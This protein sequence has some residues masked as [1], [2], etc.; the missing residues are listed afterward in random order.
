MTTSPRALEIG[1]NV[2]KFVRETIIP[3]ESDIRRDHHG[4]PTDALM[5][6][7]REKGRAS[8]VQ[9]FDIAGAPRPLRN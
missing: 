7:M 2:E 5:H 4:A 6:D 9:I 8:T 1:A 3:Y